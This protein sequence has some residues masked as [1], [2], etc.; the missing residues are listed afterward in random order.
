M[1]V[2]FFPKLIYCATCSTIIKSTFNHKI[3][4]KEIK[5]LLVKILLPSLCNSRGDKFETK[6]GFNYKHYHLIDEYIFENGGREYLLNKYGLN[7]N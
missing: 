7:T 6:W 2:L 1:Q 5:L 4:L 3:G